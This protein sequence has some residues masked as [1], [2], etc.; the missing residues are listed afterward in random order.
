MEGVIGAR[1]GELCGAG[2]VGRGVWARG[3]G[4]GYGRGA[5]ARGVGEGRGRG[6]K[7][8]TEES[9]SLDARR[10]RISRRYSTYPVAAPAPAPAAAA[11]ALLAAP[12]AQLRPPP[13]RLRLRLRR[14]RP[15]RR[16][17]CAALPAP[18]AGHRGQWRR[19]RL[20]PD[21]A[22]CDGNVGE[23]GRCA[24]VISVINAS[25]YGWAGVGALFQAS[26]KTCNHKCNR[27][28]RRGRGLVSL[29]PPTNGPS[30]RAKGAP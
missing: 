5:W 27:T 28:L 9:V 25:V 15:R 19:A 11:P 20:P 8:S 26:P 16:R 30:R 24:G 21:A 1:G 2:C 6:A 12:A 4:E 22:T 23:R 3:V 14:R 18:T 10:R 7:G 29:D 13:L 17:R